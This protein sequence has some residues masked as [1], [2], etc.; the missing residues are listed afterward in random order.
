MIRPDV[1][2]SASDVAWNLRKPC[3]D[4][5]FRR[6]APP[7]IGVAK[8]IFEYLK[9][10]NENRFSHTCHKTD[11]R[12]ECDGPRNFAG[13]RPEH[14]AGALHFLIRAGVDLQ[15]PLLQAIEAGKLN[16]AQANADAAAS[17]IVFESID[18]LIRFYLPVIK[19]AIEERRRDPLVCVT[20]PENPGDPPTMLKLS[21]ATAQNLDILPCIVCDA[22]AT[23]YDSHWP[24]DMRF[25]FCDAHGDKEGATMAEVLDELIEKLDEIAAKG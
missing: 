5:P 12:L 11:N 18:E 24:R 23:R 14:C 15:L 4:C 19:T 2:L 16:I 9:S 20:F 21:T 7:H 10:I 13:D 6:D 3:G 25:N 8:S 1:F 17:D 22:P